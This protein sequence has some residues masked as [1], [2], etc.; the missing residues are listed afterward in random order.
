MAADGSTGRVGLRGQ[1]I[2]CPSRIYL[3]LP[4]LSHPGCQL[5]LCS[6]QLALQAAHVGVRLLGRV[7]LSAQ[8]LP[9]LAQLSEGGA[10]VG[11]QPVTLQLRGGDRGRRGGG[12]CEGK[13]AVGLQL[14]FNYTDFT[15]WSLCGNQEDSHSAG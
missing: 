12:L 14:S 3:P 8:L 7:G 10:A 4:P 1:D 9:H 11:L 2:H 15:C 13:E 5:P 6:P